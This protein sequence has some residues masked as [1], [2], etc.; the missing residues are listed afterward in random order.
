MSKPLQ[1]I[2]GLGVVVIVAAVVVSTL[3][4]LFAAG[5]GWTGTGMMGGGMMGGWGMPF[6]GLGMMLWPLLIVGLAVLGTAWL[7]QNLKPPVAPPALPA[8][9]GQVCTHC[10]N[11]L[12]VG[13]KACPNCGEKV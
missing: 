12:Q 5:A 1:W 9:A 11:P 7:V 6:F 13:W 8:S 3:W 4:P 2:V 10:G